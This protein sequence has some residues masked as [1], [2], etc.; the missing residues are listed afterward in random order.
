MLIALLLHRLEALLQT[1]AIRVEGDAGGPEQLGL[2][3]LQQ[4]RVS[5]G[6]EV[7]LRL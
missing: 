5:L 2:F 7:R 1:V 6:V 3:R 4:R